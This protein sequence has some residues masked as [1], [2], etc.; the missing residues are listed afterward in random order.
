[1]NIAILGYGKEGKAIENYFKKPENNIKIF[2][3]FTDEELKN[4]NL[5]NFDLVF[6]SPSVR[7]LNKNWLSITKYFFDNCICP[8]IG[9]TGTKGKGTTCSI[10]SNLLQSFGKNVHL[11]G[12]IGNPAIEA[13]DKIKPEDVVVYELSSFQLW[14]L[15]NSPKISVVLGIKPDHLNIHKDFDEYVNAKSNIVRFQT[16]NDFCIFNSNNEVSKNISTLTKAKK[17]SYPISNRP[18]ILDEILD[19][20]FIPGQHNRENAEAALLAV[21]DFYDEEFETFLEKN[22]ELIK[23]CFKNFRGLPHRLEFLRELNNVK[24]YDDNFSTNVASTTVAINSFPKNNLVVIVGGRDKTSYEDLPELIKLLEKENIKKVILIGES[25]KEIFKLKNDEKFE[26][27]NDLNDAVSKAKT[28]A[29]KLNDAIVL[30]SPAAASF[31]MFEN[32]YDRGAKFSNLIKN[33]N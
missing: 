12:N 26:L 16:E 33:L 7:P 1:M 18:K 29:E 32:V 9:V 8:I 6:R 30:M 10:I 14:D 11:V 24:Y 2:E 22:S 4:F 15:E 13:L 31:D 21:S 17:Q 27:A 20:L 19:E 25:G 5:E 23:N 3:N 28:S